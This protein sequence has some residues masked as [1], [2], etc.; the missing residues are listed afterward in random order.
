MDGQQFLTEF[1]EAG[2]AT[3]AQDTMKDGFATLVDSEGHP[4]VANLNPKEKERY[5][6][7]KKPLSKVKKEK[8]EEGKKE[9]ES[10]KTEEKKKPESEKK[11]EEKSEKKGA[12]EKISFKDR[13]KKI[14]NLP[15]T[16]SKSESPYVDYD[17]D[18][19]ERVFSKLDPNDENSQKALND[20]EEA[21][22]KGHATTIREITNSVSNYTYDPEGYKRSL[23]SS[24][25]I[26]KKA[27][28][29]FG[30]M[31]EK[32]KNLY[33]KEKEKILPEF[34]R[35]IKEL[36]DKELS[37]KEARQRMKKIEESGGFT[38]IFPNNDVFKTWK[39]LNDGKQ[40]TEN[41]LEGIK[42][43]N[44]ATGIK[45]WIALKKDTL[46][47]YKDDIKSFFIENNLAMDS[48]EFKEIQSLLNE[49][50]NGNNSLD[51]FIN[52]VNIER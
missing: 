5:S 47:R 2:R 26:I 3:V 1:L 25:R 29:S 6:E 12:E 13:L 27:H 49:L 21:I 7:T 18:Y 46:K 16:K 36:T 8:G 38:G 41:L 44:P 33:E 35:R 42:N 50:D 32:L 10:K 31:Q 4:Y 19:T 52:N 15:F 11:T 22:K 17:K 24:E 45:S 37:D 34:K 9:P 39:N 43:Y 14:V 20:L 51:L 23:K 40:L 30:E 28:E 48:A